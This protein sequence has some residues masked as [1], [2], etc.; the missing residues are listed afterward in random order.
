MGNNTYTPEF[1]LEADQ[2]TIEAGKS[3]KSIK[4]CA[5]KLELNDRMLNGW[6]VKHRGSG[7]KS[8]TGAEDPELEAAK[9]RKRDIELEM[10][11]AFL[12]SHSLLRQN[13]A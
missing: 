12:K 11:N 2:Y 7:G 3:A 9:K 5:G 4:E 6:V 1:R 13:Q 10:E 8:T